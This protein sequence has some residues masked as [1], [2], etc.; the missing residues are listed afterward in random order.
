[1][2]NT[3]HET[4]LRNASR[5][6]ET[7]VVL[8]GADLSRTNFSGDYFRGYDLREAN[9]SKTRTITSS[10]FRDANAVVNWSNVNA[11]MVT[12][13]VTSADTRVTTDNTVN[14]GRVQRRFTNIV[15][16]RNRVP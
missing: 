12:L 5:A 8:R 3:E 7:G 9:F 4:R 1:M 15:T 6:K 10:D 13:T 11:V 16:L 14:E 2:A